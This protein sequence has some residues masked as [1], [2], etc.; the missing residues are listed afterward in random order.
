MSS[1]VDVGSGTA[2][3]T[4]IY[5]RTGQD[6]PKAEKGRHTLG[7]GLLDVNPTVVLRQQDT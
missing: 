2:L 5:G 4:R 6:R 1:P 3:I 7:V